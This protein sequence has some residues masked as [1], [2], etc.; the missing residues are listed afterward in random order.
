MRRG[1]SEL[2]HKDAARIPPRSAATARRERDDVAPPDSG[3]VRSDGLFVPAQRLQRVSEAHARG[4]VV[5][6]LRDRPAVLLGRLCMPAR[7]RQRRA[8]PR[9]KLRIAGAPARLCLV[10]LHGRD[11]VAA[12]RHGQRAPRPGANRRVAWIDGV[13]LFVPRDRLR[14]PPCLHQEVAHADK[15]QDASRVRACRLFVR[16]L[17]LCAPAQARKA[18]APVQQGPQVAP[19]A[20][21]LGQVPV[22]YLEGPCGGLDRASCNAGRIHRRRLYYECRGQVLV[23]AGQDR[24]HEPFDDAEVPHVVEPERAERV[25]QIVAKVEQA[26]KLVAHLV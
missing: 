15:R 16:R 4:R 5:G 7:Q 25:D 13:R 22:A 10:V 6:I 11:P 8:V 1:P 12:V 2:V 23:A 24:M 3:P 26:G 19:R 14:G 9:A 18:V 17:C 20:L 21:G